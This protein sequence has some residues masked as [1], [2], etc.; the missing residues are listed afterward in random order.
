MGNFCSCG[1]EYVYSPVGRSSNRSEPPIQDLQVLPQGHP[2]VQ[3][4]KIF[5]IFQ[6]KCYGTV[7]IPRP[8]AQVAPKTDVIVNPEV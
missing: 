1:S 3:F 5:L 8:D 2:D 4:I 6:N 7:R